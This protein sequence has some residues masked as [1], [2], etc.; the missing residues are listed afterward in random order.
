MSLEDEP[1]REVAEQAPVMLWWISR[2]FKR[3]WANRAWLDFTGPA[4]EEQTGFAW[5]GL[6][7]PDDSERVAEQFD[8]AFTRR[9]PAAVQ[10]RL[11]RHD[12]LY[13]WIMD[14]GVPFYREE[15]FEGFVGSCVDITELQEA[16][17]EI[18]DLRAQLRRLQGAR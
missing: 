14:Q 15:K 6:V 18:S 17:I 8:L 5:L 13:R 1:F 12:G 7:H 2:D 9:E 10:Y 11:R 4:L 16:K 3:D